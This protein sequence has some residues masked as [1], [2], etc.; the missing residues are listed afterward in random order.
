VL[1]L[2]WSAAL[3]WRQSCAGFFSRWF[4]TYLAFPVERKKNVESC[5]E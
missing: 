1:R 2:Q 4:L 5:D 3:S